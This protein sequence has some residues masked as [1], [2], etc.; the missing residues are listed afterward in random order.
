MP[1]LSPALFSFPPSFKTYAAW[2][3]WKDSARSEVRFVPLAKKVAVK[4]WH[5]ARVF[6]RSTKLAGKHGGVIGHSAL[7][8]L[9]TLIFDY[10]NFKTGRLDPSYEGIAR[11]AN[12]ARSTVAEALKRLKA[13]GLLNWVRRCVEDIVDGRYALKQE[14][15]AYAVLP[16]SQWVGFVDVPDGPPPPA[17][18]TWGNPPPMP[19]I[20]AQA[21]EA[22]RDGAGLEG[23]ARILELDPTDKLGAALA[24]L[25]RSMAAKAP[26]IT[27][28]RQPV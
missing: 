15:N 13:L 22:R 14:T 24:R 18:G 16:P 4:L 5:K 11:K 6:D 7:K 3:V 26:D 19:E 28:V 8:V 21:I 27:E 2:P 12:L 25:A 1:T 10:L 17:A 20:L 9:H 23:A